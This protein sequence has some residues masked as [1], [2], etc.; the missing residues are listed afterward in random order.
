MTNQAR[1][2]LI[3]IGNGMAGCRAVEEVLK[4]DPDRYEIVIFGAE[5]HV[6]Y[7]RIMLSPV[8]AGEK[9]FQDIILNDEAWYA[10][11]G[12]TLHTS[13]MVTSIDTVSRIV[14]ACGGV[15]EKYDKLI[16]ATGSDAVRLPLPGANLNGVITFRDLA[17]VES[18]VQASTAGGARAVIIGGGLL[19]LEAAYG[20]ARR[21]MKGAGVPPLDILIERQVDA[22]ASHPL[23]QAVQERGVENNLVRESEESVGR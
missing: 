10:D 1:E 3:V 13:C 9:K 16:L 5:P 15:V 11:N 21:G 14:F 4:R 18:M 17:D 12:I 7:N 8:L 23:T 20:L 22:S 2:R 19:G 6:N